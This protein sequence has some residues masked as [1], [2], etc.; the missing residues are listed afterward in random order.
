MAF[1]AFVAQPAT[2]IL[3]VHLEA[4]TDV[5]RYGFNSVLLLVGM[6]TGRISINASS[7]I[8]CLF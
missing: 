3:E 2:V 5:V 8:T 4:M 1:T 6:H 7:F